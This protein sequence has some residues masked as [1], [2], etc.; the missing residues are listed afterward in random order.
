M[1]LAYILM[2]YL[3][4]MWIHESDYAKIK[5]GVLVFLNIAGLVLFRYANMLADLAGLVGIQISEE[6]LPPAPLGISF[7]SFQC[8]SYI[9]DIYRGRV[10]PQR[11]PLTLAMYIALFPQLIAG[12]IVRYS[13]IKDQLSPSPLLLVDFRKGVER[14]IEGLAKKVL[15][16]DSL[17][18]YVDQIYATPPEH[19]H[20]WATWLGAGLFAMQI[21]FDFSG[22]SD[23][24]I[25]I[26]KMF[27]YRFPENFRFPSVSTSIRQFWQRWHMT[28]G[29]FFRDYLYASL[30]GRKRSSLQSARN[31]M[32]VFLITGLWHGSNWTFL[33]WGFING[34][35]VILEIYWL[36][37]VWRA[38][39]KLVRMAYA[40]S[41]L[42]IG[43]VLF[44]SPD[45]EYAG[46][47]YARMV[48]L[49]SSNIIWAFEVPLFTWDSRLLV[50]CSILFFYP[51]TPFVRRKWLAFVQNRPESVRWSA[52]YDMVSGLIYS[53]I[54]F[55][56]LLF[57]ASRTH[58]PFIYFQF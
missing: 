22:Y 15:L 9:I 29:T 48:G 54:L 46:E 16:A 28:L 30:S 33:V 45:I 4:A 41:I 18:V 34:L 36:Q 21:Y 43:A 2:N 50:A 51:T 11:N 25:G 14:F 58:T 12:P 24:A 13:E 44:R 7:F 5:L 49:L 10:E 40:I 1:L 23:M 3:G 8:I 55:T 42:A 57:I 32:I 20:V 52:T 37:K 27:G 26:G 38:E 35:L 31:L 17:S 56:S 53:G 6:D 39:M 19:L 47:F